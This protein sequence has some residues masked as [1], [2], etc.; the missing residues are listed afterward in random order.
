MSEDTD[1]PWHEE[2]VLPVLLQL[3]RRTY[4]S[5]IRTALAE[6]GFDDMPRSG[7]RLVGGI[8]RNGTAMT[9]FSRVLG[10]SKQAASQL[11]D[12]MVARGYVERVPDEADRRRMIVT[13]TDRG[14]AAAE[15]SHHAVD[16]IDAALSAEVGADAVASMRATLGALVGIGRPDD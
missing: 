16:T 13:L 11:I 8:A 2:I 6:A 4:G 9:E 3:G 15:V 1:V 14:R 5:A 10:T 7:S 12:T